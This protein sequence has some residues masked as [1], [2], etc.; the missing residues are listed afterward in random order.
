MSKID[1]VAE[2][3]EKGRAKKVGAAVQEALDAGCDPNE[4]LQKGMIDAM[5][6]VGEKFKNNEI[7]VPEMLVA[8]KAMKM[9]VEVLK[10][11]LASGA[12]GALGKVIIATV[13]GDLHDIGKNLVAMM[14]ESAGFTVIDLGVDVPIDK[15]IEAVNENPDVKIVALSA[16]LT[17]TMPSLRDTVAALNGAPFRKN[18]KVMVGG[19]PITQEFADEI[20]ADGYSEDAASAAVLAKKLVGAE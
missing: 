20:G 18:I 5:G 4:I 3:V 11:H 10:P 17:T 9:G 2:L 19:A 16:L 13:A 14:I 12:T 1:E 8:A 6:V 7:F 15:I